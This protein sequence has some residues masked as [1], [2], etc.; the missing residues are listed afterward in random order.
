[1]A[2]EADVVVTNHALL[3]IDALG[4]GGILPEHRVV[5]VDEAHE[6][7]DRVTVGGHRRAVGDRDRVRGAADRASW[8]TT[9]RSPG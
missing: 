9:R 7:V 1:M 8:P 6:L 2:A 4:D 3:A 5:I